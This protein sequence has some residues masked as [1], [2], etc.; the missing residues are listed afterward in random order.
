MSALQWAQAEVCRTGS[1][2]SSSMECSCCT[3]GLP[4]SPQGRGRSPA[5]WALIEGSTELFVHVFRCSDSFDEGEIKQVRRIPIF[6][7]DACTRFEQR[8]V[9]IYAQVANYCLH[10]L[11][12]TGKIETKPQRTAYA[13]SREASY[14][15]ERR[16]MA[17]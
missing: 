12:E 8:T 17:S 16:L 6:P 3:Q 1:S 14:R 11:L 15:S 7:E 10:E 2:N 13:E 5:V 4:C 9:A